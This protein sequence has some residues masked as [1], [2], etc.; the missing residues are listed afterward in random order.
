MIYLYIK[1]KV[2][3]NH[4]TAVTPVI[5]ED[6]CKI[7][8]RD[9]PTSYRVSPKPKQSIHG[10]GNKQDECSWNIYD[11]MGNT[12]GKFREIILLDTVLY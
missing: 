6:C 9:S 12:G 5:N 10:A 7:V 2:K 4:T 3:K 1:P 11:K 8:E